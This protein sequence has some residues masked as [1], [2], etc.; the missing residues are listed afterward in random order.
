MKVVYFGCWKDKGHYVRAL[1]GISRYS[2]EEYAFTDTNPWKY[3]IDSGL[4]PTGQEIEGVC[5]IHH[6]D[7][8]TA[9]SYWDRSID[10]RGK[11]N[12][13]FFAEGIFTFNEMIEIAKK[14]APTVINRLKSPLIEYIK[15]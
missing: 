7:G 9:L 14:Y 6:K 4:C 1:S 5:A 11:S 3:E 10:N 12:S 15:Q 8:W 13:N 2:K